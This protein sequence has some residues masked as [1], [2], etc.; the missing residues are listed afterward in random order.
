MGASHCGGFSC[1]GV[2]A[3]GCTGFSSCV[4]SVVV[5][6]GL[7]STG[8]AVVARGLVAPQHVGSSQIR[9]RTWVSC[10]GRKILYP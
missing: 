9:D 8:S 4:G 3:P 7:Q 10:I 1:C 6:P 2:Q 5:A